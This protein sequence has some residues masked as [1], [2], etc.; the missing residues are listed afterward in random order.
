MGLCT[1]R[2]RLC[3]V[4]L[5]DGKGDEHLVR[6]APG[7]KYDAPN[8]KAVL[9]DPARLKL[10]HFDRFDL[11]AIEHYLGVTAAQVFCTKIASKLTRTDSARHGH[12]KLVEEL[13][14]E[15]IENTE[16]LSEWRC[17]MVND[18]PRAVTP[19]KG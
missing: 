9:A 14:G 17:Q 12:K 19:S 5:S 18:A 10:Y 4:Q 3:L 2:D 8:L 1:H 11:A 13:M 7:S 6:C 16:Q 15:N